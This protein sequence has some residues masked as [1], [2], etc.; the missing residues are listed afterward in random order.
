MLPLHAGDP[1]PQPHG[2]CGALVS[3][4]E[5]GVGAP[6]S[7]GWSEK[8]AKKNRAIAGSTEGLRG[9]QDGGP[10]APT[11]LIQNQQL[12]GRVVCKQPTGAHCLSALI[13]GQVF[14]DEV[15]DQF[16]PHPCQL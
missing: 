1:G 5:P 6:S 2:L 4:R 12:K 11:R 3:S 15:L 16:E 10:A 9:G 8:A 13:T 7:T 14:L